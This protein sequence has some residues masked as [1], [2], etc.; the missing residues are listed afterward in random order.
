MVPNRDLDLIGKN[1]ADHRARKLR[2]VNLLALLHESEARQ[3]IV[4]LPAGE[5]TDPTESGVDSANPCAVSLSP[6]HALVVGRRDFPPF[7]H[8]A[9]IRVKNQWRV[10]KGAAVALIH[11]NHQHHSMLRR[12]LR[13]GLGDRGRYLHGPSAQAQMTR[14]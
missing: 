8:Q 6:H 13:T 11:A 10:I 2:A 9:T 5:R 7:Q 12:R 3:W 4:M 1:L 14:R